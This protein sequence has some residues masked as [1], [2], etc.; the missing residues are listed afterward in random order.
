MKVSWRIQCGRSS[1]PSY[2]G[3]HLKKC[4]Y[5]V[6]IYEKLNKILNASTFNNQNRL[7]L[8]YHYPRDLNTAKQCIRGF[9]SFINEYPEA[10]LKQFPNY[11]FIASKLSHL[12]FESYLIQ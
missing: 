6:V 1:P 5:D 4:G 2:I 11:Y 7:H 3:L 9:Q 8:G 12:N 10:V